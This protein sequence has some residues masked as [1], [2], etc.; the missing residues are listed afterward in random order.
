VLPLE[1][2][3]YLR[4]SG[5]PR[6]LVLGLIVCLLALVFLYFGTYVLVVGTLRGL[7][8]PPF[9]ERGKLEFLIVPAVL[10]SLGLPFA[11]IAIRLLAARRRRD[12]GLF[13]P[14][15]LRISGAGM[16]ALAIVVIAE[17]PRNAQRWSDAVTVTTMGVACWVLAARRTPKDPAEPVAD[18]PGSTL[19]G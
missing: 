9:P 16:V 12:G 11:W 1:I 10:L 2:E 15:V 13:S 17:S 3:R 14:L 19:P 5:R 7:F 6:E 4:P 8:A 18:Q